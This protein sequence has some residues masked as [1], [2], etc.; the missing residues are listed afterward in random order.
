MDK[1]WIYMYIYNDYVP[2]N[3]WK[4]KYSVWFQYK[5]NVQFKYL[6]SE[7]IYIDCLNYSSNCKNRGK[8]KGPGSNSNISKYKHVVN[9]LTWI[10]YSDY[11][12]QPIYFQNTTQNSCHMTGVITVH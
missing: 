10:H 8:M 6:C 1:K 3:E 9:S 2:R 5:V 4:T 7:S 11:E 12:W